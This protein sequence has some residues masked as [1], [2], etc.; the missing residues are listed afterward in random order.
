MSFHNSFINSTIICNGK[1]DVDIDALNL[2]ASGGINELCQCS[3]KNEKGHHH[4]IY[5]TDD[6]IPLSQLQAGLTFENVIDILS[7]AMAMIKQLKA[8]NLVLDDIKNAKE[9]VFKADDVFKFIY[10]PIEHKPN[11]H[12]RDYLLKLISVIHHKDI[13][14]TQL[15][16]DIRKRKDDQ[17]LIDYMAE[18]LA[19]FG[20]YD[21]FSE[22]GTSLLSDEGETTVLNQAD[23]D[24][25]NGS[26]EGETTVLSQAD[27]NSMNGQVEEL[28][29]NE[30]A[31]YSYE[32][33]AEGETTVLSQA[34]F[35]SMNGSS[36]GET[37]VLSQADYNSMNG[38]VEELVE[39]EQAS[40]SYEGSAEGETTVLSQ[41]DFDSM[42]GSSEG[43]TTV[44]SQVNYDE[45][46]ELRVE[47]QTTSTTM[48]YADESSECATTVLTSEP[49]FAHHV[50]AG[51]IDSDYSLYFI[52][53]LNGEKISIDV[54]PFTIGKDSN[55]MD[56]VIN[57]NSV[58]RHHATIIYED[59]SYYIM[60]NHSTNGTTIEGIRLQPDE[61]AEIG[62][63]YI[64][65][66]GNESFQAHIERR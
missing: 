32:G 59:G 8:N 61:R 44:L 40:Y 17:Q 63:G 54:T 27:Y 43:E 18:F 22:E 6:L 45:D 60:D 19:S 1:K 37:T 39:N 33:S 55:N 56:F 10:I 62:N 34:D 15:I 13:R 64:I 5:E 48:Y 2:L 66:L 50:T 7:S 26:S 65:S 46:D 23:F 42:N 53:N 25:M 14:L 24:N 58:S 36:E 29:E 12:V 49:V 11:L 3:Y 47:T 41:A 31:S 28:V 16:K 20:Y 30:Q 51:E 35:D 4:F 52:R 57:N 9:Y 38:Q 21:S